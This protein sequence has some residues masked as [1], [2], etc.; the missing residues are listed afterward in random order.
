MRYCN[1][2]GEQLEDNARF[3]TRCGM[4]QNSYSTF[5]ARS[6]S[7][8]PY[9]QRPADIYGMKWYKFLIYFSLFAGAVIDLVQGIGL[10]SGMIYYVQSNGTVTAGDVYRYYGA[11]LEAV[12]MFMGVS[13]LATAAFCIYTRF[14]LAEFR[15]NGPR[16]LLILNWVSVALSLFYSV[17]TIV[18]VGS[19]ASTSMASFGGALALTFT[20]RAYF[21]KR[22]ELFRNP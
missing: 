6:P 10:L 5:D 14:R 11:G 9:N 20:N 16:C 8:L 21:K 19:D 1:R 12:D 15:I 4:I 3:C 17:A 18:I 7:G 2:C 13:M 22:K